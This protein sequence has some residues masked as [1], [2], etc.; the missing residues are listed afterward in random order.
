MPTLP[1]LPLSDARKAIAQRVVETHRRSRLTNARAAELLGVN[2]TQ[3]KR[4]LDGRNIPSAEVLHRMVTVYGVSPEYLLA[5]PAAVSDFAD[6]PR[7]A[8]RAA[9]RGSKP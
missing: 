5:H 8:A 3:V 7:G 4:W 2:K 6:A 9:D 1:C